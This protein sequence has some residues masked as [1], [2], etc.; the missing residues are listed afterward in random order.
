M[1]CAELFGISSRLERKVAL[2]LVLPLVIGL[3][4]SAGGSLLMLSNAVPTWLK[5]CEGVSEDIMTSTVVQI[6]NARALF[7]EAVI[8]RAANN[9]HVYVEFAAGLLSGALA[10]TDGLARDEMLVAYEGAEGFETDNCGTAQGFIEECGY[11]SS[12]LASAGAE[13]VC[14]CDWSDARK[15]CTQSTDDAYG[16]SQ[17]ASQHPTWF[18]QSDGADANGDRYASTY[19]A[20][21]TSDET[22]LWYE[23]VVDLPGYGEAT[24]A[25]PYATA[26]ERVRNYAFLVAVISPLYNHYLGADRTMQAYAGVP[27]DGGLQGFFGCNAKTG[28]ADTWVANEAAEEYG[29]GPNGCP[30]SG[31]ALCPEGKQGYDARCRPWYSNTEDS[32]YGVYLTPPYKFTSVPPFMGN[33]FDTVLKSGSETIWLGGVDFAITPIEDK[34]AD[35]K[36]LN[37]GFGFIIT[38]TLALGSD[39]V[40]MPGFEPLCDTTTECPGGPIQ[41]PIEDWITDHRSFLDLRDAMKVSPEDDDEVAERGGEG[42]YTKGGDDWFLAYA[43]VTPRVFARDTQDF[44][45]AIPMR[46]HVYSVGITV[47]FRDITEPFDEIKASIDGGLAGV[48]SAIIV[49]LSFIVLVIMKISHSIIGT[50]TKPV[51]QL[52][53]LVKKVNRKS[54]DGQLPDLQGGSL[55]VT[56]IYEVFKK[57]Y[58]VIR[59]ANDAFFAGDPQKAK[60]VMEE[61]LTLFEA[62]NNT[63]A[64]GIAS[65][66]LGNICF[67]FYRVSVQKKEPAGTLAHHAREAIK[68]YCVAVTQAHKALV[69]HGGAGVLGPTTGVAVV[70]GRVVKAGAPPS[71]DGDAS[72]GLEAGAGAPP[73]AEHADSLADGEAH[74]QLLRQYTRRFFALAVCVAETGTPIGAPATPVEL[75]QLCDTL[76]VSGVGDGFTL[77]EF[78]LSLSLLERK[79]CV[80]FALTLTKLLEN[81]PNEAARAAASRCLAR[82]LTGYDA[83]QQAPDFPHKL[84]LQAEIA[85]CHL[86]VQ[87]GSPAPALTRAVTLL[88]ASEVLDQG[89]QIQNLQAIKAAAAAVPDAATIMARAEWDLEQLMPG[90]EKYVVM[91]VDISGSMAGRR[92]EDAKF[93]ALKIFDEHINDNDYMA[94]VTFGSTSNEIFSLQLVGERRAQ[95]RSA[96]ESSMRIRGMTA[97]YDAV[98]DCATNIARAPPSAKSYVIMLTDGEDTRSSASYAQAYQAMANAAGSPSLIVIGID[99]AYN[100]Q[101]TMRELCSVTDESLFI[102]ASGGTEAIAAAFEKVAKM[103]SG[104]D[105][106][107][108]EAM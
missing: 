87:Q 107:V 93:N 19:P 50:L 96:M 3:A 59:F 18:V 23:N 40:V 11:A 67:S 99:L 34:L 36:I 83:E 95:L 30:I 4:L 63:R 39:T 108:M 105:G 84:A 103:I 15:A 89:L 48:L 71:A 13:F 41:Q 104:G 38:P 70:T 66:N 72:G 45:L 62:L 55:E 46:E 35:T 92:L 56:A 69:E 14:D 8:Q 100:L 28:W 102:D 37:D 106:L 27:Q 58:T 97:F 79:T 33:S 81:A 31:G 74:A 98:M 29:C 2:R 77:I 51:L 60:A 53:Y 26:Y 44:T 25:T 80:A 12:D 47:P 61:A 1:T 78:V 52:L 68:Y 91:A 32:E 82:V 88:E 5:T 42:T 101:S 16:G 43:P 86:L 49:V 75:A 20:C 64:I 21:C 22:T 17:R 76:N 9:L 57:L 10:V 6:A 54:L 65:N 90:S 85:R 7:T 24:P 73:G 94:F